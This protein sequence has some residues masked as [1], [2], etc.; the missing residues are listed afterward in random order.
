MEQVPQQLERIQLKIQQLLKHHR[1]LQK[2]NQQLREE[3][4]AL[5]NQRDQQLESIDELRQQLIILKAA[6]SELSVDEKKA[7][8]KRLGQYIKEIDRCITMLSE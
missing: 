1:A 5:K 6:K 4:D 3:I 2:I 8:E 7:F